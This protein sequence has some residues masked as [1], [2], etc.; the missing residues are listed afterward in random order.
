VDILFSFE[1]PVL[2]FNKL[3]VTLTLY[4]EVGYWIGVGAVLVSAFEPLDK[5]ITVC[6][7]AKRISPRFK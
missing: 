5:T 1:G 4:V 3:V 6:P 7:L 2:T